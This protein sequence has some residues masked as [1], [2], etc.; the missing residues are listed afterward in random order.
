[1]TTGLLNWQAAHVPL[2]TRQVCRMA[3]IVDSGP[4]VAMREWGALFSHKAE[5]FMLSSACW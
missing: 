4:G 3:A 1:M 5:C 2:R